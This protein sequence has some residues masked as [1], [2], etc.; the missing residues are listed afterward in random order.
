M[1]A[2]S[3]LVRPTAALLLVGLT[4]LALAP[5]AAPMTRPASA[6][7]Q[8]I[9]FLAESRPILVRIHARID[10]KPV[11]SAWADFM[12]Y[13][14]AYLDVNGDGVLS[15]EEAERAPSVEQINTGGLTGLGGPFG[16][17]GG[18]RPTMA[19]LDADKDGKV[20]LAEL[21]AYYRKKGLAPFQFQ[22]RPAANPFG[23]QAAF[24][25][26]RV[27]PSVESVAEAIFKLLDTN[28]DG[29]LTKA[30][31]AAA[32][33]A[34][35]RLDEDGDEMI[36]PRELV[37]NA[38]PRSNMFGGMMGKSKKG[39]AGAGNRLVVPIQGP[40]SARSELVR[41]L[42]ERYGS[43]KEKKLTRK[44]LGLDEA[45][46][47]RLDADGD[48]VLDAEELARFAQL[49]PDLEVVV[50]LGERANGEAR[51]E[52]MGKGGPAL[53]GKLRVEEALALLELGLTRAELRTSEGTSSESA[54][55]GLVRQQYIAEFKK[56]DKDKNGY[57][58]EK[59]ARGSRTFRDV[60]KAMDR[61]GDGK[62]YE[63]EVLAYLDAYRQIEERAR[64]SCVSLV[65][66]DESRG[67][68]DLLDVDRD[69]RLSVREMR[70]A[71]G[72]LK[73]L[74]REGK[75]Y[76][77]RADV[78]RSY[79]LTVRLGPASEGAAAL[80]GFAALYGGGRKYEPEARAPRG[81][82]WFRKMDRNG[83]GDVSRK[84]WLL[85]EEKFRE[86]DTDGDG[87]ISVEEAERYEA[88]QRKAE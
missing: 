32:E 2:L 69:G 59:E 83:D 58:D 10:G 68:F 43:K 72:L 21:G 38:R 74:D 87:L 29:R 52:V 56:A 76:L 63:K 7:E 42:Q 17:G 33:R 14:F 53:A 9:V 45:T 86:I 20:T 18:S 80:R 50:R 54:L 40:A 78:P 82:L 1:N 64:A 79:R 8:D 84:E 62:L 23:V 31:L 22:L 47:R 88:R 19:E 61:D 44:A 57:L 4:G 11:E 25:G 6:N 28:L 5:A 48:G 67:L 39:A 24:F 3:W 12:K 70:G 27:E 15:K 30:E 41:A 65:L 37:P 55:T 85:S 77:T 16:G 49:P 66:S 81:P 46:F 60:F 34:L 73:K 71:V 51:I 35:L 75:G 36:V 26:G 13:L